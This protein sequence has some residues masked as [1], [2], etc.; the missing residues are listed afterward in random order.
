[1]RD[2]DDINKCLR[3]SQERTEPNGHIPWTCL[4]QVSFS[5]SLKIS[6]YHAW[7]S[8]F[9]SRINS[10]LWTN[11]GKNQ[12]ESKNSEQHMFKTQTLRGLGRDSERKKSLCFSTKWA[13]EGLFTK[14]GF[15]MGGQGKEGPCPAY[16]AGEVLWLLYKVHCLNPCEVTGGPSAH[17]PC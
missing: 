3:L 15:L 5:V 14:R 11:K 16:M 6:Y 13:S 1:M 9:V 12:Q 7:T 17:F 10:C 4:T 8:D 2:A